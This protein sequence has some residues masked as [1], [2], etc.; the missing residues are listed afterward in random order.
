MTPDERM[1]RLATASREMGEA[2]GRMMPAFA[3]A[4]RQAGEALGRMAVVLRAAFPAA[5]IERRI[6]RARR[7]RIATMMR[8]RQ[9]RLH[10]RARIAARRQV[11]G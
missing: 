6:D 9:R 7:Q 10:R 8:R 11:F 3:R 5:P 4:A 2:I 1:E